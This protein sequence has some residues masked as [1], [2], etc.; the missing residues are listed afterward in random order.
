MR[1]ELVIDAQH[2]AL[3]IVQREVKAL[4]DA[5]LDHALKQPVQFFAFSEAM[6]LAN[7]SISLRQK[8]DAIIAVLE[9]VAAEHIAAS[10]NAGREIVA[11]GMH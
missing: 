6:L 3:L 1:P 2:D 7:R 10:T 9:P 5:A 4:A 8:L 11:T